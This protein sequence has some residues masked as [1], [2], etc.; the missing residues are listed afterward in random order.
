MS[1]PKVQTHG[2]RTGSQRK[3]FI[4]SRRTEDGNSLVGQW[5]GTLLYQVK[6]WVQ[7]PLRTKISQASSTA[8]SEKKKSGGGGRN[9]TKYSR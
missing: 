9:E 3:S 8:W 6:A 2:A 5:L 4:V 7:S 1:N